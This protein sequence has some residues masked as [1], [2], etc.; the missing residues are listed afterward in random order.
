MVW[1]GGV[2]G[3]RLLCRKLDIVLGSRKSRRRALEVRVKKFIPGIGESDFRQFREA[4]Y[5]YVDKTKLV[6]DLLED[7][8]KILLFPRPRRFGK[9]FNLSM[10]AYFLRRTDE[11]L[12]PL[13]EGLEVTRNPQA[14][15]H[16]QKY[17]VVFVTFK[18]VKANSFAA[19]MTGI[20]EQVIAAFDEYRHLLDEGEL[21]PTSAS[22]FQRI[23]SGQA[24]NDELQYSF[25]WLSKALYKHYGQRV[26][27]LIDEYDTPVQS[28]YTGGFFD[29]VVGFFRNFF[30]AALKDNKALFKGVMTGVLR[31]SKE[32]MFSGLNHIMVHSIIDKPYNTAFGFTD[33][34]VAAIIEPERLD[35][36]RSW[37]N[38]YLFGGRV[39]YNPWSI[40]HYIREG[41]LKPYWVNSGSSDLI[42]TLALKRGLGLSQKSEALLTGGTIDI[43]IDSDIVL[44]DIDKNPDAFWNF[45]LFSGY[46]KTVDIQLIMGRYFA[47]LAIPNLEVQIVY[48]SMFR[49]WLLR[50][51]PES[52][53]TRA[54]VKALLC[55][56]A[57]TVQKTLRH[58]LLTAMSY[59]DAGGDEPEK[60]YHGFILGLLVH[61]EKTYEV[62]SNRESGFGRADMLMRPKT[63]GQPGVVIEF[64]TLD[65]DEVVDAVLKDA[66]KQ[67][68]ARRYAAEL[69]AAGAAP[70]HEYVIVFDGKKTW[71]KL[72]DDAL[73]AAT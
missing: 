51:D 5:G 45:L 69:L 52:D 22:Q 58:I 71:V 30:S 34:E 12:S 73:A 33:E 40:L 68:R 42:E 1:R 2:D 53:Y 61:L 59:Y 49:N 39:I 60:L 10:L 50:A 70:V 56:D 48:E 4:G 54:L 36:V 43:A 19:A 3:H 35:E 29:E 31:V 11:D 41:L 24:S 16:F 25:Q 20:R 21:D 66:A 13:F 72:V 26:V 46:L 9:T 7:S 55:G 62:R 47:K 27:I 57:S 28:G 64:K 15:A 38:G 18:D 44:R 8:S 65:E 32:N 37:Y 17:P 23:L 14:M 67:V 63:P 6:G